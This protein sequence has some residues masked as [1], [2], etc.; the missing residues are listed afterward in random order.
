MMSPLLQS[1]IKHCKI[2]LIIG[3]VLLVVCA[4]LAIWAGGGTIPEEKTWEETETVVQKNDTADYILPNRGNA[5]Y[6]GILA[7]M[8]GSRNVGSVYGVSNGT[9]D[10]WLI[11]SYPTGGGGV[12]GDYLFA[13]NATTYAYIDVVIPKNKNYTSVDL[14]LTNYDSFSGRDYRIYFTVYATVMKSNYEEVREARTARE[15][16]ISFYRAI[17]GFPSIVGIIMIVVSLCY[18]AFYSLRFPKKIPQAPAPMYAPPPAYAPPP[19]P[20][21]VAPVNK[22]PH[23]GADVQPSWK[24]CPFCRNK[25]PLACPHCGATIQMGWKACPSCGGN[26]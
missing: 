4:P 1:R 2:L 3:L 5:Y 15:N 18:L 19:M 10:V 7:G 24:A 6:C 12:A 17:F 20:V 25:L 26:I 8:E 21:P 9:I 11:G 14:Y 22:C 13:K 23:C 16:T